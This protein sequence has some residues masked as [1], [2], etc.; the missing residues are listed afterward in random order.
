MWLEISESQEIKS[1]PK[2]LPPAG[3]NEGVK[4]QVIS[5]EEMVTFVTEPAEMPACL[6]VMPSVQL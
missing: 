3:Q 1:N 2:L 4:F 6:F 5:R